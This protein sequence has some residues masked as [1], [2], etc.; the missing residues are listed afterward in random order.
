MFLAI[1]LFIVAYILLVAAVCVT[2]KRAT[3]RIEE[4]YP[5]L[6]PPDRE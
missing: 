3:Q 4:D 2:L 1:L 6:S 5:L